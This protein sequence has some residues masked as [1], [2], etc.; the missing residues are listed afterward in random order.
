MA[1]STFRLREKGTSVQYKREVRTTSSAGSNPMM[2]LL[3]KAK[4]AGFSPQYV[5]QRVLPFWWDDEIARSPAGL[6]QAAALVARHTGLDFESLR[7]GSTPRFRNAECRFKHAA[8]TVEND[9]NLARALG[10]QLATF[11]ALGTTTP[12]SQLPSTGSEVREAIL[13]DGQIVNLKSLVDYCW[14]IGVMVLQF[15]ELPNNAKRMHAMATIANGRPAILVCHK[16]TE[17]HLLFDVAHELG[18]LGLQHVRDGESLVDE[19]IDRDS[20]DSEELAANAYA[21]CA[22]IGEA[23]RLRLRGGRRFPDASQ[24]ALI[25]RSTENEHQVDAGHCVLNYAHTMARKGVGS[26]NAFWGTASAALK[27]LGVR[28]DGLSVISEAASEQIQ[29]EELPDDAREFAKGL[30]IAKP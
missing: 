11:A 17:A 22:I 6:A 8:G 25:G 30:L 27:L 14:R 29:W 26:P 9:L 12:V 3:D 4:V 1:Q 10:F 24:L 7:E 15:S 18:H 2:P 20:K 28:F 21:L 23:V 16:S 13:K 19:T 5:R